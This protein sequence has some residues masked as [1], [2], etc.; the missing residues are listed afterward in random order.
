VN[1]RLAPGDDGRSVLSHVRRAVNDPTVE[2]APADPARYP[3]ACEASRVSPDDSPAYGVLSR[4]IRET[5]PRVVVAPYLVAGGTDA[6]HYEGL[7]DNV[8]RFLP[9]RLGADDLARIHGA[10]ERIAR[11]GYAAAV[12][13]YARLVRNFNR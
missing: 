6:R 4:T 13:F 5:F 3:P 7:S 2:V 9:V 12:R 11:R 10:D 8:Y 1:F